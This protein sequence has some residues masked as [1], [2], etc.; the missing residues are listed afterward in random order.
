MSKQSSSA[1]ERF[2]R[3]SGFPRDAAPAPESQRSE[4]PRSAPARTETWTAASL[5]TRHSPEFTGLLNLWHKLISGVMDRHKMD[6][7]GGTLFELLAKGQNMRIH[8]ARRRVGGVTPDIVEKLIPG[9][10]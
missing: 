9:N 10:H 4:V 2:P 1:P 6:R 3:G 5:G 8:R 7:I